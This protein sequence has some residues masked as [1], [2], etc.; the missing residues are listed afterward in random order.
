[1][2]SSSILCVLGAALVAASP[3]HNKLHKKAIAWEVVTDIVTVTVTAGA[4]SSKG[5]IFIEHTVLV[6]PIEAPETT[7]KSTTTKV[8]T[9]STPPPPPPPKTT[10]TPPPPPKTTSTPPPPPPA[11]KTTSSPAPVIIVPT[12]S[13]QPAPA[14][15]PAGYSGAVEY[16]H[17]LHRTNHSAPAIV[18]NQT[19]ADWAANTASTCVFAHDMDQGTRN[20]GQN[21]DAVGM[22]DAVSNWNPANVVA[23]S[24]TD[25]WYYSEY[26][27]FADYYNVPSPPMGGNE[28]LHFT[29]VVWKGT[30]SAGC[31]SQYCGLNTVLGGS[32]GWFTVC[33]YFPAG[34]MEGSFNVDVGPP[35]NDA[36]VK[37]AFP[38]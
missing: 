10:S 34:N 6:E 22:S 35:V 14:A 2:R 26:E 15:A 24:V 37:V 20:Y 32:Y 19:L 18:W 21:I 5:P 29:Q 30:Q 38:S 11:P 23:Y 31:A 9:T 1:M 4:T 13:P 16:Y 27:N 3:V 28:Y 36:S 17:N 12:P 33:N 7:S 25:G 8:H